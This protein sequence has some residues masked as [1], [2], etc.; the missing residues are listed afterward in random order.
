MYLVVSDTCY[1]IIYSVSFCVSVY[2]VT[3]G[4]GGGG[5]GGGGG[6]Q[7]Y[8][9]DIPLHGTKMKKKQ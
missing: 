5:G 6:G 8:T 3:N 1:N 2:C 7:N 9:S 4:R